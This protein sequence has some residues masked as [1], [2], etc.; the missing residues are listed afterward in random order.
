MKE[1]P[2]WWP[3]HGVYLVDGLYGGGCSHKTYF[4]AMH[5]YPILIY[6]S[7]HKVLVF[8]FSRLP[9][10][11]SNGGLRSKRALSKEDG[12]MIRMKKQ[13]RLNPTSKL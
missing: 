12:I 6:D 9:V 13:T 5:S 2:F 7:N 3:V 4:L 8:F 11:L 10:L 1:V